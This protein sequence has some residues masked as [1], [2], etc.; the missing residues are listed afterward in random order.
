MIKQ[1]L[2]RYGQKAL[3]LGAGIIS[4]LTGASVIP[5]HQL[6]YWLAVGAVLMYLQ[7]FIKDEVIPELDDTDS[8]G[9]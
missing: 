2:A 3:A 8:A 5:E 7:T 6:K 1:T 9:A 4:A